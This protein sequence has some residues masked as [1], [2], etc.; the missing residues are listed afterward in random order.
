MYTP[1]LDRQRLE[2]RLE[3][4]ASLVAEIPERRIGGRVRSC[5]GQLIIGAGLARQAGLG[6]VCRVRGRD[7]ELLAEVVGFEEEEVRLLAYEDPVGLTAGAEIVRDR[8]LRRVRPDISW[9]GRV[10]DAMGRPLDGGSP[11]LPGPRAYM[12][13]QRPIAAE[14]RRLIGE[15]L[16]LGVRALDL[17][18]PCCLGQRLGIFA[19]S[20][21]GKSSLLSMIARNSDADVLVIGLIGERGRELNEFLHRT[22]GERGRARSVIIVATSDAPAML[23]RRAAYL[24]LTVAEYFRDR[25]MRVLCLLD[26]VTRFAMALREIYLAA[27]ELPASRGYPP[28]VFAELPMLLERAGPGEEE[29]SITGLFTVL[30]EG[31]DFNEPVTDAVRGVLDGHVVLDR[32]IAERGRF[33]AVDVLRSLSRAAPGCYGEGE[34]ELIREARR[35][36]AAYGDMA[37]LIELGAYRPGSSPD[38]DRAIALRPAIEDLLSQSVEE[39]ARRDGCDGF[40][41]LRRILARGDDAETAP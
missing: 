25:G 29:G 12:L 5:T 36:L 39:A 35:L 18:V 3:R 2:E 32:A 19:G 37:E 17:F 38:V 30:V 15:R 22:L 13:R 31:D 6:E 14:R 16:H 11:P 23:R 1:E 28:G 26:S 34:A 9:R 24:T 21:V 41:M 4:L 7:R 27:G 10:L 20:G 8:D 33:P 40:D